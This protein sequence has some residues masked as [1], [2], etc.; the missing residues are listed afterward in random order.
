MEIANNV[1]RNVNHVF[2]HLQIA[3]NVSLQTETSVQTV[4]VLVVNMKIQALLVLLAIIPAQN[5]Q[6]ICHRLA[7]PANKIE[8]LILAIPYA[9]VTRHISRILV[10]EIC[11]LRATIPA[12]N[13]LE[14]T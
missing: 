3:W 4:L 5:A 1:T 9:S 10:R 2:L 11:V 7:R 14:I 6:I 13:A 8:H 12:K